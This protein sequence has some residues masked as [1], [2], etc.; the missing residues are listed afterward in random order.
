MDNLDGIIA[1]ATRRIAPEY[2]QL[3]V[4]GGP[5]IYRERVYTYELY[6]QLRCQW[7]EQDKT[8]FRLNGEV[9]K[10]AHPLLSKLDM[11]LPI[12]D[13]LVH[14]PGAMDFNYA[15]IEVK[16]Q[17]ANMVGIKK[18]ML[19]LSEFMTKAGYKR[20]IYLH[21]GYDLPGKLVEVL[22]LEATAL[23]APAI[24]VWLHSAPLKPA[25]QLT[26]VRG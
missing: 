1:E 21:Y 7:P 10:R 19:T 14:G 8:P 22:Q 23:K 17:T 3:P 2:F 15:V 26:T 5:A 13:L 24:E 4:E 20:A 6:H 18:D 11:R 9:D 25:H 16:P 12:P